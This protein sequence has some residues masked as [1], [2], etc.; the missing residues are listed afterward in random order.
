M[1]SPLQIAVLVGAP[2]HTDAWHGLPASSLALASALALIPDTEVQVR[3]TTELSGLADTGLLV[4]TVGGDPDATSNPDAAALDAILAAHAQG[5]P[6]LALHSSLYAFGGDP[7]WVALLGGRWVPGVSGHP[8][9][10]TAT[11]QIVPV[12][13]STTAPSFPVIDERYT[14]LE[15]HP[16]SRVIAT[17]LENG[18]QHP[19]VWVRDDGTARVAYSALGHD[20][21]SYTSAGHRMLLT[22]LVGW[23]RRDAS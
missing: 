5:V 22:R 12:E 17:H 3:T 15:V 9:L 16:D 23:V 20:E 18:V 10:G 7:R 2:P 1:N 11:V 6:V 19:L 21:R 14:G 4:V 8:P 13:P